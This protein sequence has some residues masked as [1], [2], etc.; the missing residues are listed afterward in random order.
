MTWIRAAVRPVQRFVRRTPVERRLLIWSFLLLLAL[1]VGL[2]LMPLV[3][4]QRV[5][6]RVVRNGRGQ[7]DD[8]PSPDTLAWAVTVAGSYAPGATCLVRALSLYTLL[9]AYGWPARLC[10][11]FARAL[12]GTLEGHAWIEGPGQSLIGIDLRRPYVTLPLFEE[13]RPS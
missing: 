4:L 8:R 1:T 3:S 12:D 13:V 5:I 7:R 6:R 11:G 2:R 9:E 10:V